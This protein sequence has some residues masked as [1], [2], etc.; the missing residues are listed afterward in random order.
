MT[1]PRVTQPRRR[2]RTAVLAGVI[3]A[4]VALGAATAVGTS[5]WLWRGDRDRAIELVRNI[6]ARQ[7]RN[8]ILLIGD[9]MGDAEITLAR[10]HG[11]GAK[12]EPLAMETLPFSGELLTWNLQYGP[13]P[14]HAPN[15]VPAQTLL[16]VLY[17]A[18]T[19]GGKP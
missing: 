10:D 8:V 18:K 13:G 12:G 5:G 15:F 1:S 7:P 17:E 4:C 2:R 11:R 16:L 9:G 19:R 6:D 14:E 3:A